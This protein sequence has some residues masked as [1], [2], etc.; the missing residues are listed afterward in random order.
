MAFKRTRYAGV[1]GKTVEYVETTYEEDF[2]FIHVCFDDKIALSFSVVSGVILY[3]A[4]LYNEI[5]GNQ[6]VLKEY[7]RPKHHLR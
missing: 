7:V 5:T 4:A 1:E 2:I 3:H 6:E